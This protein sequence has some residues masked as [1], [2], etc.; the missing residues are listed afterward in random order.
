MF[1]I[2]GRKEN[3]KEMRYF[4][5][6]VS[7]TFNVRFSDPPS[8]FPDYLTHLELIKDKYSDKVNNRELITGFYV[9]MGTLAK[10]KLDMGSVVEYESKLNKVL[11]FGVQGLNPEMPIEYTI[12]SEDHQ[13]SPN[14]V[15][16]YCLSIQPSNI[17]ATSLVKYFESNLSEVVIGTYP[18]KYDMFTQFGLKV[19]P[20][21]GILIF[22]KIN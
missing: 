11:F 17:T 9:L 22:K 6:R 2:G 8:C 15:I 5:C 1:S 4:N 13:I 19:G 10:I 18:T 3:R 12:N 7:S 14:C 20:R 21:D 16:S